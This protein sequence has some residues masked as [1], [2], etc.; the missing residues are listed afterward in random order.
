MLF[1]KPLPLLGYVL[2]ES[3]VAGA[4]RQESINIA[5]STDHVSRGESRKDSDLHRPAGPLETSSTKTVKTSEQ[6]LT[7]FKFQLSISFPWPIRRRL[8]N[9]N[10]K[11]PD[12]QTGL[13]GGLNVHPFPADVPV[14]D[15][16]NTFDRRCRRR[17]VDQFSKRRQTPT[18]TVIVCMDRGTLMVSQWVLAAESSPIVKAKNG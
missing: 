11:K 16:D 8:L 9:G 12:P 2:L 17:V 1:F 6:T 13:N 5:P 4:I 10:H 18:V 15:G 7:P 3:H 14:Q